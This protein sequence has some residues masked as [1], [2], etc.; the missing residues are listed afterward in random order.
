V[1]ELILDQLSLTK[2]A[3]G[4]FVQMKEMTRNQGQLTERAKTSCISGVHVLFN[5]SLF[6]KETNETLF[7][8]ESSL[9]FSY[10]SLRMSTHTDADTHRASIHLFF[11]PLFRLRGLVW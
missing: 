2:R 3:R 1:T 5:R 6:R 11:S 7:Y 8:F 10:L 9:S 4:Q